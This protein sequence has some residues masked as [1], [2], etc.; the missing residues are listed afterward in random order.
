[1]PVSFKGGTGSTTINGNANPMTI[2]GTIGIIPPTWTTATR[3]SS[4]V[5][6]QQGWNTNIG[7]EIYINS[8]WRTILA[9]A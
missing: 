9:K 7:Y 6:A 4:P 8:A 1:V 2:D 5:N 3:P